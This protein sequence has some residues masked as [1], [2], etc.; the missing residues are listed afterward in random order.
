MKGNPAY[1][2][3]AALIVVAIAVFS[4]FRWR[5]IFS[6]SG[7]NGA[8]ARSLIASLL[9]APLFVAACAHETEYPPSL[10]SP[11]ALDAFEAQ[12][13]TPIQSQAM[14]YGGG[15]EWTFETEPACRIYVRE[16]GDE[17]AEPWI[18]VHG[19]FG[20]EHSYLLDVF[21][22]L[23]REVRL[24]FFD[25]RGSLRSHC[26]TELVTIDAHVGDIERLRTHLGLERVNLVGHSMG[27]HLAARYLQ[28]Y[29]QS[30]GR[31]VLLAPAYLRRPLDGADLAA[32]PEAA[33]TGA[34]AAR[35]MNREIV[36]E[37]I[38]AEG[39]NA[40]GLGPRERDFAWRIRFAGV[41]SVSV[42]HWREFRGGGAF[43]AGAA[44]QAAF[45]TMPQDFDLVSVLKAHHAPVSV[46]MG[47]HDFIDPGAGLAR[48]W[49]ED[50][51]NVSL[52]VIGNAGHNV[53]LDA[54]REFRA[55]LV[56]A[57][58]LVGN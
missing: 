15:V 52:T 25:Q 5:K 48:H 7:H 2:G 31:V 17:D 22:G 27:T 19:G 47:D 9:S 29:G 21:S 30:T 11:E 10:A 12:L 57:M 51:P 56:G 50:D 42:R 43:Y 53:W 6:K 23:E 33:D 37:Q 41:N 24:I 1:G 38:E 34:A 20:A 18:V 8:I 36:T 46:I 4:N 28:A 54:P 3:M 45:Q 14:S 39:F 32:N 26:A 13:R 49:F 35:M 40:E 58:G 44:G 55:A 16:Y